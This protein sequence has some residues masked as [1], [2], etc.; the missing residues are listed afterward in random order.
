[1]KLVKVL[2]NN[3]T[4]HDYKIYVGNIGEKTTEEEL[5]NFFK[6]KL[7]SLLYCKIIYDNNTNKSKGFGFLHLS[8][9]KE[10]DQLL[11]TEKDIYFH[12]KKLT[13]K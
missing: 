8:D 5:T 7:K 10:F 11:S 13:I 6:K 3:T 1:M 4:N 2:N 9:K 12:H